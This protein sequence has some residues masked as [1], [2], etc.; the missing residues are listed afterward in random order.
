MLDSRLRGNDGKE[1]NEKYIWDATRKT[2]LRFYT[3]DN[4]YISDK[5]TDGIFTIAKK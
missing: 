5:E 1:E 2:L 4:D 3:P